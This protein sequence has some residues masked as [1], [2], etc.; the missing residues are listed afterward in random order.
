MPQYDMKPQP[1]EWAV[2]DDLSQGRQTAWPR[3]NRADR[4]SET[5]G[6]RARPSV[7]ALWRWRN[8]GGNGQWQKSTIFL[9]IVEY[10]RVAQS[11]RGRQVT[12]YPA[13]I[14]GPGVV[15]GAEN[16]PKEIAEVIPGAASKVI[17]IGA[18]PAPKPVKVGAW[19]RQ[20]FVSH[21]SRTQPQTEEEHQ[22]FML[23]L[24]AAD[25]YL[26]DDEFE[27][28][29]PDEF[30]DKLR[31][32]T[33][34]IKDKDLRARFGLRIKQALIPLRFTLKAAWKNPPRRRPHAQNTNLLDARIGGYLWLGLDL[35]R[36]EEHAREMINRYS[37]LQFV[38][39]YRSGALPEKSFAIVSY[40]TAKLGSGRV[41][42]M[43]TRHVHQ[44]YRDEHNRLQTRSVEVCACPTCGAVV[45]EEYDDEDGSP[46]ADKIITPAQAVEWVGLH[47]R[48][49]QAPQP[50]R[51]WDEERGKHVTLVTDE[52]GERYV[53]GA[54]L[55][56]VSDLRRMPAASVAKRVKKFFGAL[57]VDELHKCKAKGT[58]VGWALTVLNNACR[59]TVG[60]TG[61]LFGGYS[62]SIFW[63][64]HRLSGEVRRE[65][66]YSD[67]RR[68]VEKYGLLKNTFYVEDPKAIPE[69][70]AYTG[71]REY[72]SV[73]EMPG[74]SPAIAG[75]GLKYCTF[76]SLND[77]GLPLPDYSEEI[78]RLDLTDAMQAQMK[79]ADGQPDEAEGLFRWAMA[80]KQEEDGKGAISV[81]LNTALNRPDAMFRGE[82]VVFHPRVSG[83]GRFAVRREE[84]VLTLPPVVGPGEWLPKEMWTAHQCLIERDQ[85]YKTLIGVRQTGTRDI[86]PRLVQALEASGLRAGIL[87]PSLAPAKRATW[88]KNHAHEFDVLL[89]NARLVEVGL[90]LTMFNTA[91]LF[92][93][94]WSPLRALAVHAPVVSAGCVQAREVV[95]PGVS[96]HA[97]RKRAGLA[98]PQDAGRAAL[99]W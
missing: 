13:L 4:V 31:Q 15:T 17:T 87:R 47:R 10:V 34:R 8:Y 30:M 81:W 61:T 91:I 79:Q 76:S 7:L 85:G 97:R 1:W 82:H 45:V 28:L 32:I 74:I 99:L 35:P 26:R 40:E 66:G 63:L 12:A 83:R 69:D 29:A 37:L 64:L 98:R 65:F 67:E 11:R 41:P 21:V 60:L 6:D 73:S 22:Q 52:H 23:E 50:R 16:W 3:G 14:V 20:Q 90:N 77:V 95:L 46:L 92:E 53:C 27:G 39:D 5:P 51:V 9:A 56:E 75:I 43:V 62:T 88:I 78:V 25:E 48:Y 38:A 96:E 36:E 86:Q 24:K 89:T 70:G 18:K 2:F 72:L 68:W 80:R 42:A 49:C 94:E 84:S 44:K 55:F 57:G 33:R 71:T 19:L 59:Y 54:P 93:F 58:G